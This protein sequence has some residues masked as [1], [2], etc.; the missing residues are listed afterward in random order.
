MVPV[1]LD[2]IFPYFRISRRDG[3]STFANGAF[4]F[5]FSFIALFLFWDL[6]SIVICFTL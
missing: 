1:F 3:A 4:S 6:V 2:V 5:F